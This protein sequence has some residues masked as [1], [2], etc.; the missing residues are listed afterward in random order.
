[1]DVSAKLKK[2]IF[3]KID[4]DLSEVNFHPYG[5]ELWIINLEDKSW[6]FVGDCEGTTWFNQIFFDNFFRL[7]S[8]NSKEYSPLLKIWFE[9]KT[10]IPI[11]K[12]SRRNTNY[13]YMLDGILNRSA[14]E[15][16]WTIKRRWGFSYPMVKKYI[17][18]KKSLQTEQI[19]IKDLKWHS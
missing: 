16:D 9:E 13:D 2:F 4:S 17:D 11:R 15:Y 10:S 14:K 6:Y 19:K 5:K 8:L 7:F 1:M 18:L 12:I 3:D